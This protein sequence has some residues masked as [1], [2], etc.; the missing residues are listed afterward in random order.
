MKIICIINYPRNILNKIPKKN[1]LKKVIT[2]QINLLQKNID[3][4]KILKKNKLFDLNK[5]FY[6][7]N[8][9]KL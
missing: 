1:I 4:L 7:Q 2:F 5:R 8:L 6:H 3:I 9:T